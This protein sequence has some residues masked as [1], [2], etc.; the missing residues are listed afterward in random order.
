MKIFGKV[1]DKSTGEALPYVN[2]YFAKNK[3]G[4][5]G[6]QNYGTT[7]NE[8]GRYRLDW[9][10]DTWITASMVGY[11]KQTIALPY[12]YDSDQEINFELQPS[13]TLLQQFEITATPIKKSNKILIVSAILMAVAGIWFW[14][15]KRA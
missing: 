14:A 5:I 13:T 8:M 2:V 7:T 1:I 3:D 15:K 12:N 6:P 10:A 4:V 11:N 9:P